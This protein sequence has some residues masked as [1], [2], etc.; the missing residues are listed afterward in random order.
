MAK[1]HHCLISIIAHV[2]VIVME[3][4]GERNNN[5]EET[6]VSKKSKTDMFRT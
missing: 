2:H 1:L 4:V 5:M 3:A 6:K